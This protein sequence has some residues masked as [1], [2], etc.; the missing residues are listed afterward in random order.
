MIVQG[1]DKEEEGENN[2]AKNLAVNE[3]DEAATSKV[4]HEDLTDEEKKLV[5]LLAIEQT[6]TEIDNV[7]KQRMNYKWVSSF[8][9]VVG[10]FFLIGWAILPLLNFLFNS[11]KEG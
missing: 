1:R 2:A 4:L 10:L 5:K 3:D 11:S 6:L 9:V 8:V 7:Q